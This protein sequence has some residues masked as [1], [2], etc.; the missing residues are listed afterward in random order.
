MYQVREKKKVN[1]GKLLFN[2]YIVFIHD[3]K[4]SLYLVAKIPALNFAIYE[5]IYSKGEA[6][7]LY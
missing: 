6:S 7:P 5:P 2:K 3:C 4:I 1:W